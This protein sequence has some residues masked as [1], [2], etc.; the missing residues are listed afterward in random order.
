MNAS[1]MPAALAAALA[2]IAAPMIDAAAQSQKFTHQR[3]AA[4][5][6]LDRPS[7]AFWRCIDCYPDGWR[8]RSTARGWDNTC[9]NVPWLPSAFACSAK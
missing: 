4:Y 9:V 2:M 8:Y 5:K 6:L 1:I 3:H 7:I